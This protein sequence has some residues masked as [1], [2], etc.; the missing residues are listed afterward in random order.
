MGFA[1]RTQRAGAAL[2]CAVRQA[3]G[4]AQLHECLREIA[5]VPRGVNCA[6]FFADAPPHAHI[7]RRVGAD[8]QP[9]DH[10][11]NV[12]VHGG[13]GRFK[14]DGGD[15]PGG[16][17]A[18]TGQ[19]ADGGKLP[20]ELAAVLLH[21]ALRRL[22]QVAH[23]GIVAEALPEL[24][25]HVLGR[26][27]QRSDI[28]QTLEKAEIIAADGFNARLLQHD[29]RE[30]DVIRLTVA[31]PWQVAAVFRKPRQQQAG[32]LLKHVLFLLKTQ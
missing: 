19:G 24:Q 21:D 11:Q 7:G 27:C 31:P 23:T 15:G 2:R 28:R 30:P 16:I 4:R 9:Q 5:A 14:A 17:V 22:L 26:A 32:Q 1:E 12:A 18:D 8:R 20:R 10:A 3:D 13:S 25:Q 6:Q 29:L